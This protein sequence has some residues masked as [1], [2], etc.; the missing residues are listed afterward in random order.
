MHGRS[1]SY[2]LRKTSPLFNFHNL[3]SRAKYAFTSWF[4][5][6]EITKIYLLFSDSLPEDLSKEA[7]LEISVPNEE[8]VASLNKNPDADLISAKKAIF[9]RRAC[10]IPQVIRINLQKRISFNFLIFSGSG[11]INLP[12]RPVPPNRPIQPHQ[13]GAGELR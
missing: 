7:D 1:V 5:R 11:R 10:S 4:Y 3:D 13:N 12:D 9:L 8:K 6:N 2:H